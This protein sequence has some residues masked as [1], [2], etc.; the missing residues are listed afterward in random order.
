MRYEILIKAADLRVEA[1][2][3]IE[4]RYP[5]WRQLNVMREGGEPLAAMTAFIDAVRAASD[6]LEVLEPI[7]G[8]FASDHRWPIP[9][10]QEA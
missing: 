6:Q 8:D 1:A 10:A 3:R 5:I 7:P 4:A 9:A 2:R